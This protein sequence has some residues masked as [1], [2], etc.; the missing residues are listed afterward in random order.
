MDLTKTAEAL[1]NE[2]MKSAVFKR[3]RKQR[4]IWTEKLTA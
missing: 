2:G 3:Q 1:K 4:N